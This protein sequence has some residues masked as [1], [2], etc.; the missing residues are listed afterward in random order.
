MNMKNPHSFMSVFIAC[1]LILGVDSSSAKDPSPSPTPF[2]DVAAFRR[3]MSQRH[4]LKAKKDPRRKDELKI[5]AKL[6]GW[7]P[8]WPGP[9]TALAVREAE[10]GSVRQAEKDFQTAL[11]LSDGWP[12]GPAAYA[13]FLLSQGRK[14]EARELL[15]SL[16]GLYPDD[17]WVAR[18]E[19]L[20]IAETDGV[21]AA[22]S[23]ES[24]K[25]GSNLADDA[26]FQAARIRFS[27]GEYDVC[28][29]NL[30]RLRANHPE[31]RD[32]MEWQWRC[33]AASGRVQ[34]AVSLRT[35]IASVGHECP[36]L[37][38]WVESLATQSAGNALVYY[39]QAVA[40]Y[41][42]CPELWRKLAMTQETQGRTSDALASYQRAKD[43]LGDS[44]AFVNQRMKELGGRIPTGRSIKQ[45]RPVWMGSAGRT[46]AGLKG[47]VFVQESDIPMALLER[48]AKDK[49]VAQDFRGWVGG[50]KTRYPVS[51]ALLI[52]Q[53]YETEGLVS[54]A[55][56]VLAAA[57]RTRPLDPRV[58]EPSC[59]LLE[60]EGRWAEVEAVCRRW[61]RSETGERPLVWM[62]RCLVHQGRHREAEPFLREALERHPDSFF[63]WEEWIQTIGKLSGEDAASMEV[64]RWVQWEPL[65][66]FAWEEARKRKNVALLQG[67]DEIS[68]HVIERLK[69]RKMN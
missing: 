42:Y 67:M 32:V 22:R 51:A 57:S 23:W 33:A 17:R 60:K 28:R 27:A 62:G 1:F 59:R 52:A 24:L 43:G 29:E 49:K 50:W 25:V 37:V 16:A 36:D 40:R 11:K 12:G 41:P 4:E 30:K 18:Q 66:I 64:W 21:K 46:L 53:S 58:Y 8:T 14:D 68:G 10:V 6:V 65:N 26:L 55:L 19:A 48:I 5:L 34:E 38:E 3:T 9:W 47:R 2:L 63:A 31:C 15:R 69:K 61:M 13:S 44:D 56:E 45:R 54:D 35:E 39:Q 20:A 7:V